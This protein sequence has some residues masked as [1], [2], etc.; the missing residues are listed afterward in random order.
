MNGLP[1][2]TLICLVQ[3]KKVHLFLM[4]IIFRTYQNFNSSIFDLIS[5]ETEVKQTTG[6]SL[7]LAK[8][9]DFLNHFCNY[10]KLTAEIG[11]IKI[12]DYSK[13][14]INSELL[15][16]ESKRADIVIKF[17]KN[18][19]PDFLLLFEAKSISVETNSEKI[20][21][22]LNSYIKKN[23]STIF[24]NFKIHKVLLT[25]NKIFEDGYITITW[26]EIVELLLNYKSRNE[27]INDYIH[28]LSNIKK[29]MKFYE[30]EVYSIPAGNSYK[31]QSKYPF[32]YECPNRGNFIMKK[33]PLFLTFR[34]KGGT[35]EKL[36]G[37]EDKIIMNPQ[38]DLFDFYQSDY[39]DEIKNRI[40]KYVEAFWGQDS[41]PNEKH[42][43]FILSE[44][45]QIML[46]HKP[47]PKKN[48][49][50]RAYYKLSE[51][52]NEKKIIV[53]TEN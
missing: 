10:K 38:Q 30:K 26:D 11:K 32:I 37:L 39:S 36:F 48:N 27:L 49:S 8:N 6:F 51:L 1:R 31:Y 43:F 35:M 28:F 5:G 47:K 13:I 7:L 25:R 3:Q 45:N 21:G 9:S 12:K 19:K 22:Q 18:N 53:N 15:L 33:K 23:K 4:E 44:T 40:K 17:Y 41:L 52:L 29:S 42:Q 2:Q 14:V 34:N 16:D 20:C 46:K 50:F 24:A